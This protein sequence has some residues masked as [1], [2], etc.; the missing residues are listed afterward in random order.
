MAKLHHNVG[1]FI[2]R[3]A[4][5]GTLPI[6]ADISIILGDAIVDVGTG[7]VFQIFETKF[8]SSVDNIKQVWSHNSMLG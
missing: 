7:I 6:G 3:F 5:L 8:L 1:K 4:Y 2:N